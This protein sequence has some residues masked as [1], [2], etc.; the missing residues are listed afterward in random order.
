[1]QA[2]LTTLP[3]V[4]NVKS[5]APNGKP[6][7]LKMRLFQVPQCILSGYNAQWCFRQLQTAECRSCGIQRLR[8]CKNDTVSMLPR[9]DE[10]SVRRGFGLN[11][12]LHGLYTVQ[13]V[14]VSPEYVCLASCP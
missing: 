10:Q 7:L 6:V 8:Y 13:G 11:R 1:M 12:T 14:T 3:T 2:V 4:I 9:P 5:W